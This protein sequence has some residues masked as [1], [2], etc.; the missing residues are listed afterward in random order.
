MSSPLAEGAVAK[1]LLLVVLLFL[2]TIG[3]T[4]I[5]DEITSFRL[6]ND[7]VP[8][9]YD[10]HITTRIHEDQFDFN[11]TVYIK[12]FVKNS[13]NKIVLHSKDLTI[14]SL[15]LVDIEK[16]VALDNI[17]YKLLD[18]YSMLVVYSASNDVLV[19]D[20]ETLLK[21]GK[22]YLLSIQYSG[23]LNNVHNNRTFGIYAASYKDSANKTV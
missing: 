3:S 7:T 10:L 20:E 13:T 19:D 2:A 21:E 15:S 6:M 18:H 5:E 12:V 17:V 1:P 23:Q 9:H 16:S 8:L 11:G 14:L 22:M 4:V